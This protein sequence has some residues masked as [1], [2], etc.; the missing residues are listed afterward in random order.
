MT[1]KRGRSGEWI[2]DN[3][4]THPTTATNREDELA[5]T[6]VDSKLLLLGKKRFYKE[7][8]SIE[9]AR[10]KKVGSYSTLM[11]LLRMQA[12]NGFRTH[13]PIFM[14]LASTTHGELATETIEM[15]EII[16]M[17]YAAK[18]TKEG[19]RDDGQSVTA[20]TARLRTLMR[21][22]VQVAIARGQGRRL[23]AQGMPGYTTRAATLKRLRNQIGAPPPHQNHSQGGT[24][25]KQS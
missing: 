22:E 4:T 5:R 13:E 7:G 18:L 1:E 21:T 12:D 16:I 8:A 3:T 2:T 9:K 24:K 20:L 15:Q 11:S 23:V 19:P 25:H 10:A 17:R 6:T 14:A